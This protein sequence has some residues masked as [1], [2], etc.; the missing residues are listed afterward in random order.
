MGCTIQHGGATDLRPKAQRMPTVKAVN[1]PVTDLTFG[2]GKRNCN[3][4]GCGS[5]Q[6]HGPVIL[7][8]SSWLAQW[9]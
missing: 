8:P 9:C 2:K 3:E 4:F 5:K 7:G 1:I 6:L